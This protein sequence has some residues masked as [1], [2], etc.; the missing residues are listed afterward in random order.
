[1]RDDPW[2]AHRSWES[3]DGGTSNAA[4]IMPTPVRRGEQSCTRGKD[5]VTNNR[6]IIA[7]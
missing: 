4:F 1:M 3:G 6:T 7:T 5:L 2:L